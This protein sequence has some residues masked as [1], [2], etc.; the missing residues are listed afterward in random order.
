MVLPPL[1]LS[2][3]YVAKERK[4]RILFKGKYGGKGS[5]KGMAKGAFSGNC[6]KCGLPGHSAK[7]CP[8]PPKPKGKG[9]G[10]IC[11]GC[12]QEG[13]PQRLCPNAQA[14][15]GNPKGKGKGQQ[16]CCKQISNLEHKK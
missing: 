6:D 5:K 11:W 14:N 15:G 10:L 8:S 12:G 1:P 9:K 13:H 7:F 4:C 16:A 3:R 2:V